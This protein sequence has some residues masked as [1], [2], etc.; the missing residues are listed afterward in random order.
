M[1]RIKHCDLCKRDVQPIK[2][3]NWIVFLLLCLTGI[4]GIFY[5][6]YYWLLKSKNTCPICANTKLTKAKTVETVLDK[7]RKQF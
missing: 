7:V 2:K 1:A 3:F 6:L 5:I 4:G